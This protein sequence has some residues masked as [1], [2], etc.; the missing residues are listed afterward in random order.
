MHLLSV[1]IYSFSERTQKKSLT[2]PPHVKFT[3][4]VEHAT[5]T[6][7][8][9]LE[10]TAYAA[11]PGFHCSALPKALQEDLYTV[12]GTPPGL[13]PQQLTSTLQTLNSRLWIS[14]ASL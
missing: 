3:L 9:N 12:S 8:G 7:I 1:C 2:F 11:I 13:K 6:P 10:P 14:N 5:L 4:A